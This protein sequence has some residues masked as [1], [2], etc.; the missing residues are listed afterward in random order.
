MG[1]TG[2]EGGKYWVPTLEGGEEQVSIVRHTALPRE[3]PGAGNLGDSCKDEVSTLLGEG[4]ERRWSFILKV[5]IRF[6]P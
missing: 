3:I 6:S 1:V 4:Y 2:E 5:S